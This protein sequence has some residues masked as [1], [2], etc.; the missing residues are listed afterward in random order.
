M[1]SIAP[2]NPPRISVAMLRSPASADS[3]FGNGKNLSARATESAF[4][5]ARPTLAQLMVT[6]LLPPALGNGGAIL[7]STA[8][9][10]N[11]TAAAQCRRIASERTESGRWRESRHR[12]S[13]WQAASSG[14]QDLVA[15]VAGL[16]DFLS[17]LAEDVA[18][19]DVA[20]VAGAQRIVGHPTEGLVAMVLLP[21]GYEG[22]IHDRIV[23]AMQQRAR[24]LRQVGA[25]G[26]QRVAVEEAG[27]ARLEQHRHDL[28]LPEHQL[29]PHR[30][31]GDGLADLHVIDAPE[32]VRAAHQLHAAVGFVAAVDGHASGQHVRPQTTFLVPIGIVLVP[33]PPALRARA[34]HGQ[35]GMPVVAA[36]AQQRLGAV[37]H[38]GD[39]RHLAEVGVAGLGPA[40]DL[41]G[42]AVAVGDGADAAAD[43]GVGQA[44][45]PQR[46]DLGGGKE[47]GYDDIAI[48][49]EVRHL[50]G[51]ERP[52]R[53]H[54]FV[55]Q[56]NVRHAHLPFVR[57]LGPH[58]TG[59]TP[60]GKCE[61]ARI[62]QMARARI[63][64]GTY[65]ALSCFAVATRARIFNDRRAVLLGTGRATWNSS[66]RSAAT[67]LRWS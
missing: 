56:R 39:E 48:A 43:R 22:R 5:S 11:N 4:G 59:S 51:R 49:V 40:D 42:V 46:L 33:V 44:G 26:V 47:A 34:L 21:L 35:L 53:L 32:V 29:Q 12:R 19:V 1:K 67:V 3:E 66:V 37:D 31:E 41:L 36:L 20:P 14:L 24:P 63:R 62:R 60:K 30:V 2:F 8:S 16:A 27:V 65:L 57:S 6:I 38:A 25:R 28:A 64:R 18:F 13:R 58:L 61:S 55:R 52:L 15:V 54:R 50:P 9:P 45:L 7:A 23:R 17:A 10:D